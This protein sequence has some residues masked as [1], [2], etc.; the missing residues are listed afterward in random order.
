MTWVNAALC[1][2]KHWNLVKEIILGFQG[3][4]VLVTKAIAAASDP[5]V[6]GALTTIF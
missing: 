4:G 5:T 1:Y 3:E 6:P 2:W